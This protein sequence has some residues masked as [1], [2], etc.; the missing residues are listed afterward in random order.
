VEGR[1]PFLD[2]KFVEL[3]MSIPTR[4]KTQRSELKYILKKSVRGLIPDEII[5]RK[6]QGFAVPIQEW[7]S[8][9]LGIRAKDEL[10]S[11][12]QETDLLDWAEVNRML[13]E[14]RGKTRAWILLNLALWWKQYMQ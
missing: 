14:P 4:I 12:C 13:A 7:F 1:V 3:V 5:D 9:E 8:E 10:R 11:F 6:K 2:H